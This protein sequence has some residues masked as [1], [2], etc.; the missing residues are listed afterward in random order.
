MSLRVGVTASWGT[1]QL[2]LTFV[3]GIVPVWPG[4]RSLWG[5]AITFDCY[6]F[7]RHTLIILNTRPVN[8]QCVEIILHHSGNRQLLEN[9]FNNV[10]INT[11]VTEFVSKNR[12]VIKIGFWLLFLMIF[13]FL[14]QPA[15]QTQNDIYSLG[16]PFQKSASPFPITSSLMYPDVSVIMKE[17][18]IH[19]NL[20]LFTML[21]YFILV[22]F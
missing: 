15:T 19:F 7:D 8:L 5:G 17:R 21:Q 18:N 10:I 1:L 22:R 6:V 4:C 14:Q 20:R 9:H 13:Q 3:L 11:G 12:C 2:F 16:L